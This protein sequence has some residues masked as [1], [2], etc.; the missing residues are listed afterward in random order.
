VGPDAHT[1]SGEAGACG[2][3]LVFDTAHAS[4]H[5]TGA[6]AGG[7]ARA[8][9]GAARRAPEAGGQEGQEG[10]EAGGATPGEEG[11]TQTPTREEGDEEGD[12][13]AGEEGRRPKAPL[14]VDR[15]SHQRAAAT[16]R[17]PVPYFP[18]WPFH[19][20]IRMLRRL[21]LLT[22]LLVSMLVACSGPGSGKTAWTGATVLTGTGAAVANA[23]I[24]VA[25]GRIEALGPADQVRV[26]RGT[27]V[28]DVGGRWIIPG[29]IDSHVHAE[30]WTLPGFL[31]YGVT[32]VRD[33][34]GIQD[35]VIFLRDDI[36]V[37]A[38]QGPRLYVSGAM[39]DAPPAAWAGATVVRTPSDARRAVGNR[40]LIGATQ[41]KVYTKLDARLLAPLMDEAKALEMPVAAH[42]GRVDAV[43]AARMGV[44]SLEHIGGVVEAALG[45]RSGLFEA[46]ADFFRGWN[47]SERAWSRVDSAPLQRIA[48]Q[49]VAA[50]VAIVPTL[51]LH[52]AW[53]HLGDEAYA[54]AVDVSKMPA[55]AVNAWNV[56][57]L[58]R[59]AGITAGDFAAF[60]RSRPNQDRFVR[61]FHRARGLVAAGSDSPNQLLP[62]GA[63]LHRELALLVGAGL[64]PEQAL[65]AATRDAA[66][67]LD[68]D[69]IGVLRPGAVADFVVLRA[70][71][72]RDIAHVARIEEVVAAGS[73]VARAPAPQ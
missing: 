67:L 59:R 35:S 69:S 65:F 1:T 55:G 20:E 42:L 68:A 24:I 61:L 12:A 2:A 46:H 41:I 25:D 9:A 47:A 26:P 66:R 5:T 54:R 31:A 48:D 60:Q 23:V 8:Q 73:L 43:T 6:A 32:S 51:A 16:Q 45:P 50:G 27:T 58:V 71:P 57:D 70:D 10:N 62:P 38:A 49:L 17:P 3:H 19:G 22:L 21:P 30:R 36:A 34:G 4:T 15:T 14:G 40:V 52:D 72:R 64:T 18:R 13:A 63:S 7:D 11:R 29:L 56:P 33:A 53:A 44:R 39:V 37:G 28:R